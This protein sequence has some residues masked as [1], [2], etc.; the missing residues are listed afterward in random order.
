MIRLGMLLG[1]LVWLFVVPDVHG[2]PRIPR[3]GL[4]SVGTDPARPLPPQ[5]IAFFEGLRQLGY[6]DGQGIVVDRRF[7]GG[8]SERYRALPPSWWTAMST[9]SW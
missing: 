6:V 1:L 7:A 3:I 9:S 2:Q 4:L 5:W 8:Q